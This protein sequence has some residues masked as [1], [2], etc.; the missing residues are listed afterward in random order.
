MAFCWGVGSRNLLLLAVC[1]SAL[2][3]E[4][5]SFRHYGPS[6]GLTNVVVYSLLQDKTGFI[7]AGT[8]NGLFRFDGRE[9]RRFD[10]ASVAGSPA[11][12]ALVEIDG[13]Q[14]LVGTSCG[15]VRLEGNQFKPVPLGRKTQLE[16]S[17][18]L[19]SE[20]SSSALL[21]VEAGLARITLNGR[22]KWISNRPAQTALT[23][24]TGKT[25]VASEDHLYRLQGDALVPVDAEIGLPREAWLSL[26]AD[27]EGGLLIANRQHLYHWKRGAARVEGPAPITGIWTLSNQ[28][29]GSLKIPTSTGLAVSDAHGWRTIGARGGLL[30]DSVLIT[31]RDREGSLWLGLGGG[32]LARWRGEDRWTNWTVQDGLPGEVVWSARR[33]RTGRLWVSTNRGIAL[34]ERGKVTRVL[35]PNVPTEGLAVARDNS[36]WAL[37][38]TRGVV[39]FR[40]LRR[41]D[42]YALPDRSISHADQAIAI[43][44]NENVWVSTSHGL[45]R[46]RSRAG[47]VRFEPVP[48]PGGGGSACRQ[49]FEDR[50]GRL[51]VPCSTGLYRGDG[52]KWRRL[53]TADGLK[54]DDIAA[55]AES[56][57]GDL[58]IA[59]MEWGGLARLRWRAENA[60]E[61]SNLPGN[62]G[63]QSQRIYFL[64]FD[65]GGSLWA[66]TDR[67]LDVL[68][69]GNWRHYDSNNGLVWDDC[70]RDGF[71]EEADGTIWIS[72]S[73]G[74]S[75]F[76]PERSLRDLA[77][78]VQISRI[79]LDDRL[80][81]NGLNS[82]HIPH[83]V[84][85]LEIQFAALTSTDEAGARFRYRLLG[86]NER[87]TETKLN[88]VRYAELPPGNYQFEVLGRNSFGRW[89]NAPARLAFSVLPPWWRT[90]WFYAA[91][92]TAFSAALRCVWKWRVKAML[93]AQRKLE[94]AVAERTRELN[95]AKAKAEQSNHLKSEF[96][97]NMS[98]EIRTPMNGIIGMNSLLLESKLDRSQR[99]WSEA[100]DKSGRVL[101]DLINQLLDLSKVEAGAM[102]LER[103]PVNLHQVLSDTVGLL[104]PKAQE[105]G[106]ALTLDYPANLP[107]CFWGDALRLRQMTLNYIGNALKFTATGSVQL[108]VRG[109][110]EEMDCWRIRVEVEDTGIGIAPDVQPLLFQNFQQG[111]TSMTRK[112]GGTGL[113]LALTKN[114]A[115]LMGGTVGLSSAEKTGSLFWFEVPL[116][117][118]PAPV[119]AEPQALSKGRARNP[120]PSVLAGAH[121]LL[122][123]D[124]RINQRLA[125]ILL[126]KRGVKVTVAAD[127]LEALQCWSAA[128]F[129]AILMDCQ[130]PQMDGYTATQEIRKR[131][132]GRERTPILAMTANAM[133]SDRERCLSVGMDDYLTK[134]L[135]IAE[136]DQLLQRWLPRSVAV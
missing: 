100:V 103:C 18:N 113:G 24:G 12:R 85:S 51:W 135:V 93:A 90:N 65:R 37:T 2:R 59:Y 107:R 89:S 117:E 122:V 29:A 15:V 109:T 86:S 79:Q 132:G 14:I 32:G 63:P 58:W 19:A 17:A 71:L 43:D 56:P 16:S 39:R 64:R 20:S 106:L 136:L 87:W 78:A 95:E 45:V 83:S 82:L 66:G 27:S 130:M 41:S 73:G 88:Q 97:A 23:D 114:L 125:Q 116:E 55:V 42:A 44:R 131:E 111:D 98:H 3:A 25:W 110:R 13:K 31:L 68:R 84:H 46:A 6:E 40:S 105:K 33:D 96:L 99:E 101:L 49:V 38:E 128:K 91:V 108:R 9:F 36:V 123:E 72:T 53:T 69:K 7:W 30:T 102:Q 47:A 134:P 120:E 50:E 119:V 35:L 62:S 67:G 61:I 112:Y 77:P 75:R 21:A 22:V 70:D 60:P 4:R 34:M 81:E 48:L 11:I 118:A 121:I 94:S 133:S 76:H 52:E 124:N 54:R 92:I 74:L 28:D 127:G 8:P 129:D 57:E 80:E 115:E 10:P 5:Y 26:A 1:L 104:L 126:E